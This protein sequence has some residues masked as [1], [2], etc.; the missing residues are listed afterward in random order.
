VRFFGQ[1]IIGLQPAPGEEAMVVF[2]FDLDLPVYP[3]LILKPQLASV[4]NGIELR[5]EMLKITPSFTQVY[6][7]YQK[8]TQNDWMIGSSS[9]LQIGADQSPMEGYTLV[10]DADM[11]NM[12]N[13]LEPDWVIPVNAGRCVIVGFPVG[14]HNRPETLTLT[15]RELEQSLPEVIPDEQIQIARQKLRQEGIEMDWVTSS[16]NSG[17]GGAGPVITKKP[18]GMT[19]EEV[20][21]RFYEV[22][23]YYYPGPWSFVVSV[24]P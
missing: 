6:L 9:V 14:H 1:L 8:P 5:L 16:G 21:R 23:G 17:G 15:I 11:G 19:D 4:T 18:E 20:M 13:V 22:L 2:S 7:C 24:N 10:F 12:K 3:A